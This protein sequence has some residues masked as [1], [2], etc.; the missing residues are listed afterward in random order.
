MSL[1][2]YKHQFVPSDRILEL[3]FTGCSIRCNKCQNKFLQERTK[4]NTKIVTVDDILSELIDYTTVATQLHIVGGE[5]L[6]QDRREMSELL[7]KLRDMK[8]KNIV[9]FTGYN[10][11]KREILELKDILQYCD[12]LKIGS[13]D[14]TQ[15]NTTLTMDTYNLFPL[16]TKNQRVIRIRDVFNNE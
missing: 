16:A 11:K 6:E 5:P 7:K 3:Y 2:Y 9:F 1:F 14:S 12:Y 13:Y 15:I 10:L 4:D 8:Y